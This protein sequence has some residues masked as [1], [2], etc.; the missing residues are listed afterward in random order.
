MYLLNATERNY[1]FAKRCLG[2]RHASGS[3]FKR[4]LKPFFDD[5][6]K[7]LS[8]AHRDDP[9]MLSTDQSVRKRIREITQKHGHWIWSDDPTTRNRVLVEATDYMVYPEDLY[10]SNEEH[11]KM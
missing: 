4:S 8:A 9:K 6:D 10:W 5:I 1:N 3:T 2:F 7:N 11:R